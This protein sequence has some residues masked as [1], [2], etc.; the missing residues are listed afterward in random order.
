[1]KN[2]EDTI[3][4]RTRDLQICSVVPQLTAPPP[5]TIQEASSRDVSTNLQNNIYNYNYI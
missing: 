4:N 1:M 3:G 2:S 5:L